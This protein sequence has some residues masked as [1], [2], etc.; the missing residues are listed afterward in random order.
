[1]WGGG[2]LIALWLALLIVLLVLV[3]S[4]PYDH[5]VNATPLDW[6]EVFYRTG[7]IIYGGGQVWPAILKFKF[8][9]TKMQGLNI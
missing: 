4:L 1:M 5:R 8:E 9:W 3:R 6:F 7:S 2:V